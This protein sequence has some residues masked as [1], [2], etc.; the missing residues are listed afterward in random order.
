MSDVPP[1]IQNIDP[2]DTK[3]VIKASF[4]ARDVFNHTVFLRIRT[5]VEAK[6][7]RRLVVPLEIQVKAGR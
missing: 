3:P 7:R 5:N 6:T 4:L 2:Y 1:P